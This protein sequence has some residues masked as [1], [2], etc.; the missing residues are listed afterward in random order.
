MPDQRLRLLSGGAAQGAVEALAPQFR[1]E[2]GAEIV[3]AF[4]P[5]GA[6]RDRLLGG[7]PTDF[8]ILTKALV[9]ELAAA[10]H[11]LPESVADLGRVRTGVAVK[12][13]DPLPDL[14]SAPAL[15]A[16][17]LAAAEIHFPDPMRA[18]AGIHFAKVLDRLEVREALAPR[19]RPH[20]SG[21]AAM[22]AI[23]RASGSGILGCTQITEIVVTPGVALAGP[24]PREFELATI[25]SAAVCTRAASVDLARQFVARVTGDATRALR[26][27]LG[28]EL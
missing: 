4:G 2:T 16:A 1:T 22:R 19:L 7:E 28:F 15:R 26:A 24:L 9:A 3:G 13:G 5:V 17:L 25:Y 10:G 23:A 27:R 11:V 12:Q 8:V 21:A 6:M 18:T 14:S 20:A